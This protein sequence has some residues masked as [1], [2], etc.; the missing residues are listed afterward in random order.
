MPWRC[1][2]SR[3]GE[4]DEEK[5]FEELSCKAGVWATAEE[6]EAEARQREAREDSPVPDKESAMWVCKRCRNTSTVHNHNCRVCGLRRPLMQKFKAH[7]GDWFCVECNNHN[8]GYREVC[9][10]SA[11][12]TRDWVCSCGNV[13]R[14]NRKYCNRRSPPCGLPRPFNFD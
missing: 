7:L 3:Q 8:R 12:E 13:N 9:N 11:C 6:D 14:S 1:R 4:V 10:W 5:L 2:C